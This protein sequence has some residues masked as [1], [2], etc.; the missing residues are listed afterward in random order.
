[1]GTRLHCVCVALDFISLTQPQGCVPIETQLLFFLPQVLC[2]PLCVRV[3]AL[4]LARVCVWPCVWS[5]VWFLVGVVWQQLADERD[6]ADLAER[7]LQRLGPNV[8]VPE[9]VC[10]CVLPTQHVHIRFVLLLFILLC[11]ENVR[12]RKN[13]TGRER[14]KEA[15]EPVKVASC[16]P[17]LT[18]GCLNWQTHCNCFLLATTEAA[19]PTRYGTWVLKFPQR[20][21]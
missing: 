2:A 19:C 11:V 20:D 17:R 1:M 14:R 10:L 12:W 8:C 6:S 5:C 3:C 9:C 18:F 4:A 13:C 16:C 7:S 15:A 21:D